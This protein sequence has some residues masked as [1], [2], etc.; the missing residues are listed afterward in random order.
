MLFTVTV[1][2]LDS[3]GTNLNQKNKTVIKDGIQKRVM[4]KDMQPVLAIKDLE[5]WDLEALE[6]AI[7][8]TQKGGKI[9]G[10]NKGSV[11][12]DKIVT[13]KIDVARVTEE[14]AKASQSG[15]FIRHVDALVKLAGTPIQNK[16]SF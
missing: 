12:S 11:Y 16:E 3:F 4:T 9:V 2:L 15:L 8:R 13:S 7:L 6:A 1:L 5:E 14:Q 10:K